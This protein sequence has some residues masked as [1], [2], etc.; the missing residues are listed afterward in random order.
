MIKRSSVIAGGAARHRRGP[1]V[2]EARIVDLRLAGSGGGMIGWGTTPSTPDFFE[3]T[4]GPG[5][6]FELGLKLLV[7]DFSGELPAD[8]RRTAA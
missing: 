8:R 6:G 2:A 1:A 3:Q 7:F 4:R 5:F